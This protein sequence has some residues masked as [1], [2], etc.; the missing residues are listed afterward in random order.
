MPPCLRRIAT[1]LVPLAA[2]LLPLLAGPAGAQTGG[3]TYEG[4]GTDGVSH[5]R[6]APG[7][8]PLPVR[9]VD[10]AYRAD[11]TV[12]VDGRDRVFRVYVPPGLAG[13]PAPLVMGLHALYSDRRKAAD[14]M[15]WERLATAERFVVLY[16][17]GS[18]ASWNAGRC[19]GAAVRE[20][21]DDVRALVELQR[22][23]GRIHPID[24][25]RRYVTGFSN[26]GMMAV[27]LACARPDVV[28]GVLVVAGAHVTPCRPRRPVP[29]LQVHGSE[30]AVV[31]Y[32][33]TSYS[34]FLGTHLPPVT[35]TQSLWSGVNAPRSRPTQL[36]RIAGG[37]HAW[38]RTSGTTGTPY[39]TT[40]RG[41]SFL[42]AHRNLCVPAWRALGPSRRP[43]CG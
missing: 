1:L 17:Q 7:A 31:P 36:V 18:G 38:P 35:G 12:T 21:V 27:A 32:G 40:A 19:C 2:V 42:R 22:L 5:Y 26:G 25:R 39:D 29:V 24:P 37:G 3:Q 4:R 11:Y 10:S 23:A 15:G 9:P 6:V 34:D 8:V 33:G 28:A 14:L 16:P 41:W 13:R 43:L 30:D 20:G